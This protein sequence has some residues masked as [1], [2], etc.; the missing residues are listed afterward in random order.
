[1]DIKYKLID[2]SKH[3][4]T[5]DFNRVKA[6]GI[7]GVILRAGYGVSTIDERFKE[8]I[9]K[10]KEAKLH[11]GVYWFGYAY[12]DVAAEKEAQF[13]IEVLK[14]YLG[15]IDLPVF[16]DWE[17]DSYNYAVKNGV[18]PNKTSISRW[19][20]IFCSAL[21][22]AGYFVGVYGN[23]D[24]MNNYYT[25]EIKTKYTIWIAQWSSKCTYT[26]DYGIWQYGAETNKIDSKYVDGVTGIVDKN[27]CYV[28]YPRIIKEKGFNGYKIDNTQDANVDIDKSDVSQ[29]NGTS[30]IKG[31]INKD[32]KVDIHDLELLEHSY[33]YNETDKIDMSV[34]DINN[35]NIIDSTDVTEL[36]KKLINNTTQDDNKTDEIANEIQTQEKNNYPVLNSTV[37]TY[38][39]KK[40][41]A[42]FLSP[43][44]QVKE[45]AS[46]GGSTV[47][48]DNILISG[49]LINMLEKLFNK[50]NCTSIVINS[51]YRTAK[52]DKAV[53]G[54]G[55]GQHVLGK[56]ADIV[57]RN[58]NGII[59]SKIVCCVAADLGFGGVANISTK[60]QAVHVDVRTGS[61]YY[62]D[63]IRGTSSIWKYN[64]NWTDFYTYFGLTKDEINKYTA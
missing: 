54:S 60:Y 44:F 16:Y 14:P 10:A 57:C 18:T 25:D 29:N 27:Y 20:K 52:H 32:G 41:G 35:D 2:L 7:D 64:S 26:G 38:S 42:T 55:S 6:S 24:Y 15:Q 31:D 59:N 17:Y 39:Y 13:C 23:V 63:E 53:G 58:K 49:E 34:G 8:Y 62:G 22:K 56:A 30:T 9:K 45:F 4:G 12:T 5:V 37:V 11:I 19:T 47:Y 50:L 36:K 61:K 28:D 46:I 1:M 40:D 21:D 33:L 43:H 3:N 51:G 48:S